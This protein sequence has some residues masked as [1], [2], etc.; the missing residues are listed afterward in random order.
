M[1]RR[2]SSRLTSAEG[3]S[4]GSDGAGATF[5]DEELP[6]NP[7]TVFP[8]AQLGEWLVAAFGPVAADHDGFAVRLHGCD[9]DDAALGRL[10]A[11]T[12]SPKDRVFA[13]PALQ[14]ASDRMRDP[15]TGGVDMIALAAWAEAGFPRV[16]MGHRLASSLLA[17][18]VP[19][20][21]LTE[22]LPPWP[23][24]QIDL[25]SGLLHRAADGED[26]PVT[27]VIASHDNGRWAYFALRDGGT[28][29]FRRGML[30]EQI[31][32]ELR[33]DDL[34]P[35][36]PFPSSLGADNRVMGL[37]GR[38]VVNVCLELSSPECDVKQVGVGHGD[39]QRRAT[40]GS[41][42]PIGPRIHRLCRDVKVDV[43]EAVA[44]YVRGGGSSPTV[45]TLV[46]GHWKNQAHGPGLS[47]RKRIHVEPHW[48]GPEDAPIA[49]RKHRLAEE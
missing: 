34:D 37:I 49:L 5:D 28:A 16:Q 35:E 4:L 43:R 2:S 17:T 41:A 6:P 25:P 48:R 15:A 11:A 36:T 39:W 7:H 32:R 42:V 27:S 12:H 1:T 21:V 19:D 45:Q 14:A 33:A 23:A 31:T 38:L 22:V 8:D 24:F 46:R 20:D 13:E 44:D 10:D 9:T 29:G 26:H 18:H 47:L 30:A 3:W 40:R